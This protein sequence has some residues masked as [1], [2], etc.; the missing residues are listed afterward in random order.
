MLGRNWF[1]GFLGGAV[2][3]FIAPAPVLPIRSPSRSRKARPPMLMP[4]A[5]EKDHKIQEVAASDPQLE[6]AIS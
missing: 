4:T 1:V 2:A 3:Q 5:R 6:S